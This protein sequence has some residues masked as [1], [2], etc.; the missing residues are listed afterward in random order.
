[1]DEYRLTAEQA[2]TYEA[3]GFGKT[4]SSDGEQ[5]IKFWINVQKDSQIPEFDTLKEL[6]WFS[7]GFED[8]KKYTE[9]IIQMAT[10]H[11]GM[12]ISDA[13]KL[14]DKDIFS[15]VGEDIHPKDRFAVHA[16]RALKK[17]ICNYFENTEQH[18]RLRKATQK[19]IC[20]CRY[21]MD[22]DIEEAIARGKRTFEEVSKFTGAGTGCGS[23]INLLKTYL[24]KFN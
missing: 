9:A 23:C 2:E 11:G 13:L 4:K 19:I 24:G 22:H 18:E 6:K 10:E 8:Q 7:N 14:E 1:M 17:A 16:L 12:F 3:E 15:M 21:V 5:I 20:R